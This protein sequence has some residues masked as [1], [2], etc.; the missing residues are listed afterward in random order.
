MAAVKSLKKSY[1]INE[2]VKAA[3]NF[4]KASCFW[5]TM[6]ILEVAFPLRKALTQNKK[7]MLFFGK[8]FLV[9]KYL[10]VK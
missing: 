10:F 1:K 7:A 6:G 3:L 4:M 2:M 5:W 9:D 8:R